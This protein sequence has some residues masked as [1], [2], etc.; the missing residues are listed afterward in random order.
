MIDP[1]VTALFDDAIVRDKLAKYL[2]DV[3]FHVGKHVSAEGTTVVV[4]VM[5][6]PDGAAVFAADGAFEHEAKTRT[7]FRK[8]ELF[9]RHGSKSER[10]NQGDITR[11]RTEA[12]EH[13]RLWVQQ[14]DKTADLVSDIGRIIDRERPTRPDGR[15]VRL[16]QP[17]QIWTACKRLRTALG[18]LERLKGPD[19]PIA[20]R[21]AEGSQYVFLDQMMG[22]VYAHPPRSR[23]SR[24][25]A[26]TSDH[27][28]P[29]LVGTRAMVG[30]LLRRGAGG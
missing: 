28:A 3:E 12:I 25:L 9:V 22:D 19:L 18:L 30:R 15:L 10:P 21:L 20:R 5:P 11:L 29:C 26:S 14:L 7:A 4:A 17:T 23:Q 2:P 6:H 8:G 27:G 1:D 13:A 16:G 24:K